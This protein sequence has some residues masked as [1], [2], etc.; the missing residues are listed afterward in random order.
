MQINKKMEKGKFSKRFFYETCR[1]TCFAY[2][3]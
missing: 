3:E 2:L 1:R